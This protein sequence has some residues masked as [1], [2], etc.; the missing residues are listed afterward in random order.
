MGSTRESVVQSPSAPEIAIRTM[1]SDIE[2]MRA[3]GGG[4]PVPKVF[5]R[6]SPPFAREEPRPPA[7]SQS[8]I[9]LNVPG[10]TGP[11]QAIFPAGA[12]PHPQEKVPDVPLPPH[13][14][15]IQGG[16]VGRIA[17]IIAVMAMIAAGL[18]LIG[19]F[20]VFPFFFAKWAFGV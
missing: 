15:R 2:S 16:G 9:P 11:E 10:Y 13:S 17:L 14:Q 18:G 19:Y 5:N 12:A 1:A 3:S 6:P 7:E 4:A 20:V 8:A